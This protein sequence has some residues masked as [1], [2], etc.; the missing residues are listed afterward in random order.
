M[1]KVEPVGGNGGRMPHVKDIRIVKNVPR[2]N[3]CIKPTWID[4]FL[5][6]GGPFH[7]TYGNLYAYGLE[8]LLQNDRNL[9]PLAITLV[10]QKGETKRQTALAQHAVRAGDPACFRQ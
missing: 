6:K 7:R 5:N 4:K 3:N 2:Q 8:L 10:D 1:H 9:D